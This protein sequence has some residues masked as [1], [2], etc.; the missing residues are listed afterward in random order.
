MANVETTVSNLKI[1]RLTQTQL[2]NASTLSNTEA[3]WVDPE[4]TGGKVLVTDSNGDIVESTVAPADI[5]TVKTVN[6]TSPDSNGNVAI[7]IP[8]VNNASLTINQGGTLKG[9]FTANA[10]SN[11][12]VNLD[13]NQRNIGEIVQSTIPLTDAGLHLLDG[14]VILGGG[15]YSD[16]VDYIADLYDS[17]DYTDIFDTEANWQTAVTTY[18]VCGKFVYDSV[19]NT[20]RL[21]RIT[22]FTESTI[23]P[24]TLGDL[25][26]AGLP[27]ITGNFSVIIPYNAYANGAFVSPTVTVNGGSQNNNQ[28]YGVGFDASASNSIY[29]NSNT[30]QPQSIKVLYYIVIATSTKTDI[31]VDIDEIAT[32]LNGKA[33][34]D[35]T[36]VNNA[37]TSLGASWAMPSTTYE[38]LTAGASGTTY[39]APANG[40]FLINTTSTYWNNYTS[41]SNGVLSVYTSGYDNGYMTPRD[42]T[43]YLPVK[44]NDIVTISYETVSVNKFRFVYAQGS[45]SEAS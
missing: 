44:K 26:Q 6:N 28:G 24:T 5:G 23:D 20:V 38:D 34:V 35:L 18:G 10:S 2:E 14:D 15:S 16:F 7:T 41:L 21:P 8:T 1:N 25:T 27:N 4:F 9:T 31:Q 29:G 33:D 45:E 40:W 19:N 42:N 39:T 32:D 43:I 30:V 11:V 36:N 22:G 12:T 17:G 3:Y 37:G 13:G